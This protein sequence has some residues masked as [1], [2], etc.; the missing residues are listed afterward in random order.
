MPR[1][2]RPAAARSPLARAAAVTALAAL[3][4][5]GAC[6]P[7]RV[8]AP[9]MAPADPQRLVVPAGGYRQVS[10]GK[11]HAC[12]VSTDDALR[13]WGY[14]NFGQSGV[15][16]DLQAPGAVAQAEANDY[17]TCAV[18]TAGAVRCWGDPWAPSV[19]AELQLAGAATQVSVAART[20]CVV[21]PAGAL[22]CWGSGAAATPPTDLQQPG[23]VAALAAG[24]SHLCARTSAGAV[25]C[26]GYNGYGQLN[27]PAELQ[28]D[29]A[30]MQIAA[31]DNSSCAVT[32]AGAARC[33]GISIG[34]NGGETGVPADLQQAGA[35]TQVTAG[36][37]HGCATTTAGG[38]R[39]WGGLAGDLAHPPAELA[40]AGAVTQ[41]AAGNSFDCALTPAGAVRCWGAN[42]FGQLNAP[43][44]STTRVLP[45]ATFAA[46]TAPVVSGQSFALELTDAAVPGYTSTF[47]YAFDCGGGY[48]AFGAAATATCATAASATPATRT[49]K[50][51][52][53]DQGGD[54]QEYTAS[55]QLQ[56]V[57][58]IAVTSALP[59]S[60]VVTTRFTL[61]ATGG[62][63]GNAVVFASQTP[64][65]CTTGGADGTALTLVAAGACT[66]HA[67]QAGTATYA[68]APPVTLG[69]A[70]LSP[71]QAVSQLRA[72]VAGSGIKT[73]VRT[74]LTDK[75]DAALGALTRGDTGAA[76]FQL[77][78]FVSQVQAQRGRAIPAAT[79]DAWTAE[80]ARIRAALGC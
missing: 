36:S 2:S 44:V 69:L 42:N 75:L 27:V 43:V 39:C 1:Y 17:A 56:G 64:A 20:R 74:G 41:V 40:A 59:P 52:V 38:A 57:Q 23:A 68:A 24:H 14:D 33:W 70:V 37:Y 46:P 77:G 5:L 3:A 58:T 53:K 51:T 29:G 67:T 34:D 15:P 61:T 79:A 60:A 62:A 28:Q 48:G 16:A 78:A 30:A 71:A 45:T 49:V 31:G 6:A 18:T 54:T 32:A 9:P 73:A 8:T 63:S 66:V 12:A 50:G 26:W 25:R 19:P 22:R 72:A 47:T 7:E 35:V 80:A 4:A 76:C 11:G 13:C 21:T 10:A 55:V 65:T